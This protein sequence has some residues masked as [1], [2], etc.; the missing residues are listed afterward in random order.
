M[1]ESFAL[2]SPVD[3]REIQP[4]MNTQTTV[5][6]PVR[7]KLPRIRV[8]AVI[9]S[10]GLTSNGSMDVPVLPRDAAWYKLGPRP[11]EKGS[12]VISGHINWW[13][14]A[15]GVFQNLH[16][17]KQGDMI[18]VQDE[19]GT[20]TSFV[21]RAI[22]EL[23]QNQDASGVFYSYDNKSHLNLVTCSGVW[24]R[25]IQQYSKRLVVFADKVE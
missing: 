10:V 24:V 25:G 21:V 16:A 23:A 4:R 18:A 3:A 9:R 20:V 8:N 11:G 1:P 15:T 2:I 22:R 19:K 7:I 5:G 17:L 12:A 6:V 13:H 14:G